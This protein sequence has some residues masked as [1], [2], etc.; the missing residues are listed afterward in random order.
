MKGILH[1]MWL[2][3]DDSHLTDDEYDAANSLG[4][5]LATTDAATVQVTKLDEN[6]QPSTTVFVLRRPT[7]NILLVVRADGSVCVATDDIQ[8]TRWRDG[9]S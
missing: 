9:V 2:T 5:L 3:L 4:A 1:R 7:E 6:L 8:A